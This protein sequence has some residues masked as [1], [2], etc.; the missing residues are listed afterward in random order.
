MSQGPGLNSSAGTNVRF[1]SITTATATAEPT[2]IVRSTA[3]GSAVRP[4]N[5]THRVQ[6]LC[7]CVCVGGLGGGRGKA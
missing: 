1:T 4:K 3:M 2:P 7:V 6:P 5:A